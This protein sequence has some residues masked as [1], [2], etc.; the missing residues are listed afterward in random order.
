MVGVS[1]MINSRKIN[2]DEFINRGCV[3]VDTICIYYTKMRCDLKK[4][5]HDA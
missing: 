1:L 4:C 5:K 2:Q 3:G